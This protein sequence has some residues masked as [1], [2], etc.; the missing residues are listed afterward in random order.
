MWDE[1]IF[2]FDAVELF[3]ERDCEDFILRV[4]IGNL[5]KFI[6]DFNFFYHLIVSGLR[7]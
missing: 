4:E 1:G 3:V 7:Y 6:L 2:S 5:I